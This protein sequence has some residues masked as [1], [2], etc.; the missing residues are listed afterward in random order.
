MHLSD[1]RP[2]L[3]TS[4]YSRPTGLTIVL[5]KIYGY[6]K[7]VALISLFPYIFLKW[8]SFEKN[9]IPYRIF[10]KACISSLS[11]EDEREN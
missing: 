4:S 6:K 11:E 8:Q 9:I 1:E 2:I 5:T 10:E 3:G 7:L